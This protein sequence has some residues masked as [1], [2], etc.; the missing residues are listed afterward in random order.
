MIHPEASGREGTTRE[1]GEDGQGEPCR[2]VGD[3]PEDTGEPREDVEPGSGEV[4]P[5]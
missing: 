3:Y 2:G 4:K 5:L 1:A